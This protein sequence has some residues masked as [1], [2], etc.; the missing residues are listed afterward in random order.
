MTKT[1]LPTTPTSHRRGRSLEIENFLRQQIDKK[2]LSPGDRLPT[3]SALTQRFSVSRSV[4]REA[5]ASLRAEGWVE[6]RQGA[7]LFVADYHS[8]DSEQASFGNADLAETTVYVEVLELRSAVESEAAALAAER[9][10]PADI[11]RIK[12]KHAAFKKVAKAAQLASDEDLEFHL[13][14]AMATNNPQFVEFFEYIVRQTFMPVKMSAGPAKQAM[15]NAYLGEITEE[16]ERILQAI[17]S[18]KPQDA[19]DAMRQHI[20]ASMIRVQ[21]L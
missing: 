17:I 10:S 21:E 19:R 8:R 1:T 6:T 14:V 4:V 7:G 16:H 20:Q 18:R 3:E 2:Q 5:I 15:E 12:E 9:C 11:V 13:A